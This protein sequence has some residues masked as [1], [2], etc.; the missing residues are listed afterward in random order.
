MKGTSPSQAS[1]EPSGLRYTATKCQD[2]EA[3]LFIN[4]LFSGR[5]IHGNSNQFDKDGGVLV[6]RTKPNRLE[7][8]VGSTSDL[9]QSPNARRVGARGCLRA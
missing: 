4:S 5:G 2:G 6:V 8:G 7:R 3:N 9:P 1:R